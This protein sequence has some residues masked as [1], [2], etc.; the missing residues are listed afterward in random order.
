MWRAW[1]AA[2]LVVVT[3]YAGLG[4]A[5]IAPWGS[6][7][8]FA[9]NWQFGSPLGALLDPL[10]GWRYRWA[11]AA[12]C[13]VGWLWLFWRAAP[14]PHARLRAAA[15]ATALPLWLGPIA[16][17]W[18]ALPSAA[19]AA[20]SGEWVLTAWALS[21]PLSYEV[22]DRFDLDGTWVPSSW[23]LW[24]TVVVTAAAGWQARRRRANA[25]LS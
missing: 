4:L 10:L 20:L 14:T 9:Y 16:F 24:V 21:L 7:T 19:L 6:L 25:L 13:V 17:P 18:Y 8:T 15:W 3:C 11:A 22:I 12:T 1:A 5:G 2:G 23:P